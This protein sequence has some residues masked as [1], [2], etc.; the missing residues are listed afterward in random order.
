MTHRCHLHCKEHR[1]CD[2]VRVLTVC[3]ACW[4]LVPRYCDGDRTSLPTGDTWCHH[5][6]Q[7]ST[8]SLSRLP[9]HTMISGLSWTAL[10]PTCPSSRPA[11]PRWTGSCC[12]RSLPMRRCN[13]P[14]QQ[15]DNISSVSS[16]PDTR[17]TLRSKGRIFQQ[18]TNRTDHHSLRSSR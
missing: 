18:W 2:T 13:C 15:S 4:R 10:T 3:Y 9:R 14:A 12:C 11:F 1:Q 6:R 7:H 16:L 17:S 8:E 5:C